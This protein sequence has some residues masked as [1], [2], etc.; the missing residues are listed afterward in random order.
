M[1][2]LASRGYLCIAHDRRGHGGFK[3]AVPIASFF[4]PMLPSGNPM[5]RSPNLPE[6]DM[7]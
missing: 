1:F 5:E 3:P 2:Y 6:I 7:K 4:L